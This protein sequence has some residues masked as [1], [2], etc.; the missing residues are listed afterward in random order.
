MAHVDK[1]DYFIN[2]NSLYKRGAYSQNTKEHRKQRTNGFR[3]DIYI[4][5]AVE[6]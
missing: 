1:P 5:G 3:N 2:K 6:A 4:V